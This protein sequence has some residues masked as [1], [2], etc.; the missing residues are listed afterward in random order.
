MWAFEE[1]T[2]MAVTK[3]RLLE[4]GEPLLLPR[5]SGLVNTSLS[6]CSV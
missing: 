4:R 2:Q 5:L 6:C 3:R 1:S